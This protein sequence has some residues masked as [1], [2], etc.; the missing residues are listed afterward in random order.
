MLRTGLAA[1]VGFGAGALF[2]LALGEVN[3]NALQTLLSGIYGVI[4]FAAGAVVVLK[5]FKLA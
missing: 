3:P 4:V 1:V 5:L 2:T